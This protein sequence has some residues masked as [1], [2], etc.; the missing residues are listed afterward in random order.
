V[1]RT[2]FRNGVVFDGLRYRGDGMVVVEDGRIVLVGEPDASPPAERVVDLAGGLVSPG[3]VDAHVH[4]VQGGV[5][6]R[7]C[8]LSGAEGREHYLRLVREYA[9]AHPEVPWIRGGG[10]SM[11]AFE[12]GTAPA[13]DLDAVVPDRPVYLLNRDHHGAWVNT[14]ALEMAGVDAATPDPPD[15]HLDRDAD[16]NPTGTLHEGAMTVVGALLPAADPQETYAGLLEAQRHLHSLGVTGWQDAILG[17]YAGITDPAPAYLRAAETGDLTAD[18][19]GALWWDRDGGVEQVAELV[20]RRARLTHGRLRATSVKIMYD[21]IAE[22]FTAAMLGP[23]LDPAGHPTGKAGRSFLEPAA[24]SEAVAALVAENFQVHVHAIGDRA[25]REALDAFAAADRRADLRHHIAHLQVVH[26]EDVPR[27]AALGVA[28]NMQALWACL[29][30]QMVDL[31]LPFLDEERAAWQYPFGDLHRTGARLCAGSDWP[32]SSPD[33][34]AAIHV[35]VNRTAYGEPGRA[36]SE[37]FLPGQ[38]LDLAT[39]WAAYTSGSARI[40]GRDRVDGAGLLRPG[41]TADLV[42]LDRDPFTGARDEIGAARVVSTWVDGSP[43]FEA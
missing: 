43:V 32:V 26:P 5:E 3:F 18:V 35:A 17:D 13:A 11:A 34:L 1:V 28:A 2:V 24:L 39:A 21:G 42:V 33:P 27:F 12:G 22:N 30:D 8:D 19:V 7:Q 10:W 20:E 29:D 38:A 25:V 4:A 9:A 16:G 15:G 6:R 31:T 36:G 40:N 14:R 37:P 41:A 23:Y